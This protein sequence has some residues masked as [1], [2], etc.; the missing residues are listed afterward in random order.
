VSLAALFEQCKSLKTLEQRFDDENYKE[1]VFFAEDLPRWREVIEGQCG[2][3]EKLPGVEPSAAH[4]Q[5]TQRYGGLS[6]EQ[7]LYNDRG[8][9]GHT[10]I[11]FWP[12]KDKKHITLKMVIL[13]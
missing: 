10:I 13:K 3:A 5:L 7:T 12:W 9:N 11:M 1:L 6:R 2:P 4:Q 8:E